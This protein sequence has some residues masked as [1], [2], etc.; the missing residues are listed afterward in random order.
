MKA[1]FPGRI[2]ARLF[3]PFK[4]ELSGAASVEYGLLTA[5]LAVA[6]TAAAPIVKAKSS[7]ILD[8]LAAGFA[9]EPSQGERSVTVQESAKGQGSMGQGSMGRSA[10]QNTHKR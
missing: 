9:L 1:A 8:M 3:L 7:A 5:V 2:V 4:H 10:L 6:I